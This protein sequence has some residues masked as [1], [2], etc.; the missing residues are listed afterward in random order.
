[1]A[2]SKDDL[3]GIISTG[4]TI[5]PITRL[6]GPELVVMDIPGG[7]RRGVLTPMVR[8][9]ADSG[10]A[11]DVETYV[12]LL[13]RRESMVSTAVKAGVAFPHL[14]EPGAIPVERPCVVLGICPGGT[15]FN[16][17]DGGPTY[18]LIMCCSGRE[19]VHLRLMAKMAM[20]FRAD[21]MVNNIRAAETKQDVLSLLVKTDS[22]IAMSM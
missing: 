12:G 9:L 14:R 11:V 17:L 15:D 4:E 13:L 22:E 8:A 7:S 5:V 19:V 2:A 6:V 21:D 10:I 18:V 3:L 1:M 16:A 20:L